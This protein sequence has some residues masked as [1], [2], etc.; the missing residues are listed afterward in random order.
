MITTPPFNLTSKMV[1][2]AIDV[3]GL[4]EQ[5]TASEK[6]SRNQVLRKTNRIK[7]IHGS[8]S[9]EQNTLS[10]D[11]ITAIIEG[12]HVTG[13][14]KD[15]TEAENAIEIYNLLEKLDPY[16]IDDLLYAHSIMTRNLIED[17]GRFRNR[18]AGVVNQTGDII[19]LGAAPNLIPYL[20]EDLFKWVKSAEDIPMLIRSSVFHYE[21]E[22]IHP[23][24]DGNGRM[25]RLW[26]TLLLTKWKPSF[27]W[28]PVESIIHD[29]Q[30]EYYNAINESNSIGESTPFIEF[31]LPVNR[32]AVID[33]INESYK[34]MSDAKA[35]I[36]D[37][38]TMILKFLASHESISNADVRNMLSVSPA[39]ANRLLSA[40]VKKGVIE[41]QFRNRHWV[42]TLRSS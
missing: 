34:K 4:I 31:M 13:P 32:Q 3:A 20:M 7:T 38:E 1:A 10:E 42:Y 6:I 35:E 25:G 41:K 40:L 8:L 30:S 2:S 24:A 36:S 17:S 23:F 11:Q 26:Q 33:A 16:S 14:A 5:F 18:G 27:A 12:K 15:I 22:T 9:I 39:T 28:I 21:L 37:R 29:N 19:H